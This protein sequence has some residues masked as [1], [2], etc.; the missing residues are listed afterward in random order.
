MRKAGSPSSD[1]RGWLTH[2]CVLSQESPA[3]C[4]AGR[5]QLGGF[6]VGGL[7]ALN[8][9]KTLSR[10]EWGRRLSFESRPPRWPT[11]EIPHRSCGHRTPRRLNIS[12][13][14]QA[15]EA[16]FKGGQPTK[17]AA[18]VPPAPKQ[19]RRQLVQ[20][21][22]LSRLRWSPWL[23]SPLGLPRANNRVVATKPV[24]QSSRRMVVSRRWRGGCAGRRLFDWS[25]DGTSWRLRPSRTA[26]RM[27]KHRLPTGADGWQSAH[28]CGHDSSLAAVRWTSGEWSWPWPPRFI[29]RITLGDSFV[30]ECVSGHKSADFGAGRANSDPLRRSNSFRV[31]WGRSV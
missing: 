3:A 18:P 26:P 6:L 9:R 8:G 17:M 2:R 28:W 27:S 30:P 1:V 12:T 5:G 29:P 14:G 25:A 16:T 23:V 11:W 20:Q 7:I 10:N 24:P 13:G 31:G 19:D 21:A 22:P 4:E 15:Q